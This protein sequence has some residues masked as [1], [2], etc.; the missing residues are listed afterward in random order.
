MAY[1]ILRLEHVHMPA[2]FAQFLSNPLF[3]DLRDISSR[4]DVHKLKFL[5]LEWDIRGLVHLQNIVTDVRDYIWALS[6]H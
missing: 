2:L 6:Q 1:S 3:L 4:K 5:Q